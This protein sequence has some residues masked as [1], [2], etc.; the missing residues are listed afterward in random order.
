MLVTIVLAAALQVTAPKWYVVDL[1]PI[2]AIPRSTFQY[3]VTFEV[4]QPAP[5]KTPVRWG[6]TFSPAE[7][8]TAVRDHA[9]QI[10]L[11][12]P[13]RVKKL[14]ETKLMFCECLQLDV[15][16]QDYKRREFR[17][18]WRPSVKV[19]ATPEEAEKEK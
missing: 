18:E 8:P 15:T 6:V 1:A 4:H 16:T 9:Y 10:L 3:R 11:Q 12:T 14:G 17:P 2:A 5:R 7:T 13:A 19:Y